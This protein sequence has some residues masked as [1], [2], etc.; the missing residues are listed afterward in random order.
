LLG[1]Y[2]RFTT[3]ASSQ[4]SAA[5]KHAHPSKSRN[6]AYFGEGVAGVL[7]RGLAKHEIDRVDPATSNLPLD[8]FSDPLLRSARFTEILLTRSRQPGTSLNTLAREPPPADLA[9]DGVSFLVF[10]GDFRWLDPCPQ[11]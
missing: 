6:D 11:L 7:A 8:P 4:K 9:S 5:I 2:V 3:T 10:S 1:W